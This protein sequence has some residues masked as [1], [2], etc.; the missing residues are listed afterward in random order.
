MV[1]YDGESLAII[2]KQATGTAPPPVSRRLARA[3]RARE[4]AMQY[5]SRVRVCNELWRTSERA[6]TDRRG[7]RPVTSPQRRA[8]T[9]SR[10]R[11]TLAHEGIRLRAG[12]DRLSTLA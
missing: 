1:G 4:G 6:R 5:R 10:A 11:L 7:D 2:R 8:K 3:W 9:A 12:T